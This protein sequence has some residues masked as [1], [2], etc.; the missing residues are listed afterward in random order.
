MTL[1]YLDIIEIIDEWSYYIN[2]TSINYVY[3]N[4]L[5]NTLVNKNTKFEMD[6]LF[7]VY[8]EI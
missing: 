7:S 5:S 3:K 6:K 8:I 4:T 2:V 1:N